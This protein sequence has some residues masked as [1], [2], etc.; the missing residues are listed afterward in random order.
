MNE[1]PMMRGVFW[2]MGKLYI[3]FFMPHCFVP[4]ALLTPVS[5]IWKVVWNTGGMCYLF[6]GTSLL[7]MPFLKKALR[8]PRTDSTK[9]ES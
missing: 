9:K 2:V 6:F 4:F 5:R 7:W 3:S 8:P 1:N